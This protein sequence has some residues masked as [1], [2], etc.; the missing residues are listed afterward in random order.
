MPKALTATPWLAV[1]D[2]IIGAAD[3]D[4]T[5]TLARMLKAIIVE[6]NDTRTAQ[7]LDHYAYQLLRSVN[8]D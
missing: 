5:R 6:A 7:I 1:L 2:K 4:T 3:D 8:G